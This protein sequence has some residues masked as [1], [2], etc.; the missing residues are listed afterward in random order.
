MPDSQHQHR[1]FTVSDI[2]NHP[3]ISNTIAPERSEN[4]AQSLTNASWI[5]Q[6]GNLPPPLSK[7]LEA[8][9][10][11]PQLHSCCQISVVGCLLQ[12]F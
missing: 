2:T 12:P 7:E 8:Q 6:G 5:I 1:Y 10:V 3:I 4:T 9:E 11:V